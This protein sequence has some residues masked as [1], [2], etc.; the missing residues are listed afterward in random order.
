MACLEG[1]FRGMAIGRGRADVHAAALRG[2]VSDKCSDHIFSHPT[3]VGMVVVDLHQ[4][5]HHE[6]RILLQ[7]LITY[8]EAS[9]ARQDLEWKLVLS[10]GAG[11]HSTKEVLICHQAH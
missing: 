4:V 9:L 6:A 11:K 8:R 7:Q 10:V 5:V 3:R 2:I 1:V